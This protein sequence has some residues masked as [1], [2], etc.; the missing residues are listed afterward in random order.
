MGGNVPEVS[1]EVTAY[2][3][4]PSSHLQRRYV[5]VTFIVYPGTLP[6]KLF[7]GRHLKIQPCTYTKSHKSNRRLP[8]T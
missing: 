7:Q 1:L 6:P 2:I 8:I 5:V 4:I 3:E